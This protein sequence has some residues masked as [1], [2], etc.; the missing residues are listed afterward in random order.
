MVEPKN[1][2]TK[3][4]DELA[5]ANE[6]WYR[7]Y[8]KHGE[9]PW[10]SSM[11]LV[12]HVFLAFLVL[13]AA[14]PFLTPDRSPPT[15]DVIN[16]G[17]EPE[18]A[19]GETDEAPGEEAATP[20]A[21]AQEEMQPTP[22]DVAIAEAAEVAKPDAIKPDIKR[23][24]IKTEAA[25][26]AAQANA[27]KQAL[28]ENFKKKPGGGGKGSGA[29]GRAARPARWVLHFKTSSPGDY[30]AQ[31]EGLGASVAF[32]LSGSQ[33]KYAINP[34]SNPRFENRNLDNE[35]RLFWVDDRPQSVRA[36][37]EHL[38]I[39]PAPVMAAFLPLELEERMLKME[40]AYKN[41]EEDEILS[42][43][44]ECFQRGGGYDVMVVNQIPK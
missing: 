23:P 9:F 26:F 20:E 10:S 16:V 2:P 27:A 36:I 37:T 42:T 30:L 41:L 6:P 12:L 24:D 35:N 18:A 28:A 19:P 29:T 13:A 38:G 8:S 5:E 25:N 40:L 3:K 7:R 15:V 1:S 22:K 34:A 11:S 17:D 44:F 21:V 4:L 32:P 31:L 33:W 43:Q 39:P 14:K